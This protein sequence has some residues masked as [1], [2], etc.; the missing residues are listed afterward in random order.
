MQFGSKKAPPLLYRPMDTCFSP[1]KREKIH[2]YLDNIKVGSRTLGK[3]KKLVKK[4]KEHLI[5]NDMH[6]L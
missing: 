1:F 2:A 4:V 6:H 5:K 3:N